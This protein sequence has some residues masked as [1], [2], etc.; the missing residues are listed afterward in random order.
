MTIKNRS[1][2]TVF[3]LSFLVWLALTHIGDIQEVIAGL[4]VA[5]IVSMIAGEF[6][7][8]TEKSEHIIKRFISAI[9]Y[10]FKFLWEMIKAN[11]HVAYIVLNPNLPIKPGIVKIRTNLTKD[12]AITVLTNSITLTP[13]TL[14]VDVNPETREIY[15]HWID[16]LSTDVE[17]STKLIG[18]RFEKLLMEVFE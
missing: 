18:G 7:I 15:I 13:G 10:L 11:F 9:L 16:V 5:I 6:L 3:I 14:T 17:E 2:I 1:R 12:S 8:T 4:I